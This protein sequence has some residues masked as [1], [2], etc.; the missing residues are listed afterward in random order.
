MGWTA[1]IFEGFWWC[2]HLVARAHASIPLRY[3]AAHG[4]K[5]SKDIQAHLR[6]AA[7][8]VPLLDVDPHGLQPVLAAVKLL[9]AAWSVF[10]HF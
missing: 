8:F 5:R 10:S 4:L 2:G 3:P 6:V 7:L 9:A 1:A